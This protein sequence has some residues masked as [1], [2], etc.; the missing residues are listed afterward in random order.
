[1]TDNNA[2]QKRQEK[3][4]RQEVAQAKSTN[5]PRTYIDE[6]GCEVTVTA[7]GHVFYNVGD[8]Y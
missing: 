3:R 2:Q 5:Q 8:W 6:D 4:E 1:M 7:D